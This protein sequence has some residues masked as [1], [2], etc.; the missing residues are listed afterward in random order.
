MKISRRPPNTP[1]TAAHSTTR[2]KREGATAHLPHASLPSR[3]GVRAIN[4]S[5]GSTDVLDALDMDKDG[6]C[7]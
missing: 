7:S 1:H 6:W 5:N 2:S 4:S 3:K